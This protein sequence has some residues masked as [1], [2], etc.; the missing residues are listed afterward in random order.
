MTQKCH[1]RDFENNSIIEEGSIQVNIFVLDTDIQRCARYHADQHVI[2]MI[3]ESTQMLCTVVNQNG[4][5]SPYKSTHGNHPCALWAGRSL[6]NWVWLRRLALALNDEYLYRFKAP[7]DH[8][9]ARIARGLE[10]PAIA[11]PGLTEFAQVMPE[12]YRVEGD[13]V[14]AYRRFYLGDKSRFAKWTRR[15]PPEW[16][17][18]GTATRISG[19]PLGRPRRP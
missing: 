19:R 9:S 14:Q 13:A 4:G 17:T 11:D 10:P 16:Y 2:K 1:E 12:E 5:A 6:S 3:L 18:E 8:R 7:A 15:R